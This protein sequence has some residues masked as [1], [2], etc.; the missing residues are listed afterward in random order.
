[1]HTGTTSACSLSYAGYRW[2]WTPPLVWSL[3]SANTSTLHR[4]FVA[5]LTGCQS[6]RIQFKFCC[7]DIWLCPKYWSCLPQARAS[8]LSSLKLV[9]SA[10]CGD[11]VCFAGI[12]TPISQRSFTIAASVVWNALPR[13][14]HNS[15]RRF[16]SKLKIYLFRQAYNIAG[17]LWKQFIEEWI[18]TLLLVTCMETEIEVDNDEEQRCLFSCFCQQTIIIWWWVY[19]L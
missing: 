12:N 7:V 14:P 15:R 11:L 16:R 6:A 5:L 19:V 17:F 13:S 10:G 1:M 3:V 9:C 4:C 8:H 2:Y 18:K